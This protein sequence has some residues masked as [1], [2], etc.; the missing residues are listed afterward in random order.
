MKPAISRDA[1]REAMARVCAPVHIVT[2]DGEAGRGGFTATAVCS[3]SDEPPTLLVCMNGRSAQC[4]LFLQ[5]RA[6]CVNVLSPEQA[7]LATMFAGGVADMADRYGAADWS[8]LSSGNPALSDA[9]ATFDC[10][11]TSVSRVGT[12]N[13]M[14]GRVV[15]VALQ[16][17][18]SALL[19][20]DRAYRE[21]AASASRTGA[22]PR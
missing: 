19:Y 6:F 7:R 20:F 10:E 14:I 21:M 8:A 17:E 15:E 12:H 18:A 1:F 16:R 9:V 5:N 3:V 11:L 4:D 13:V 22:M 2:T